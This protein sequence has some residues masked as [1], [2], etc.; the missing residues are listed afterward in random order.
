MHTGDGA[1]AALAA[2]Q[3]GVVTTAQ[4]AAAGL[5][6]RAVAHRVAHCRLVRLHRRVYHVGPTAAP[7]SREMA[8][9]LACGDRA[10]LS[11]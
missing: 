2:G 10:A 6:R 4:L 11:H 5:G 9:V 1:V 8:A 3:H 7:L